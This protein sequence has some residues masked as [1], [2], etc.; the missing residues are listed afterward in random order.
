[1]NLEDDLRRALRREDA[2][3][4]F[5]NRVIARVEQGEKKA[6]AT[7]HQMQATRRMAAVWHM[8][9]M[10]WAAAAAM[11]TAVAGGGARYYEYQQNLAETK[12]I[13]AEFRLA[14]QITSDAL[15]TVQ[16]TLEE[17]SR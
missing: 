2:P 5:A 10:R 16:M 7:V 3:P 17:S 6:P 11:L 8:P 1:M 15:A 13:E 12:R 4:D 9:I 14:L